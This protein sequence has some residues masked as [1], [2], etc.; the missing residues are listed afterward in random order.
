MHNERLAFEH[1]RIHIMEQ[2]ADGPRKEAGLMSARCTLESLTRNEP[3]GSSFA[4][5]ICARRRAA[6]IVMPDAP[7]VYRL[8]LVA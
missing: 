8:P 4:C 7:P 3:D 6:V 1:Y 5:S 2:W